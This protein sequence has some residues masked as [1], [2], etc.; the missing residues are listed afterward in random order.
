MVFINTSIKS[1]KY[2]T[3]KKNI[4]RNNVMRSLQKSEVLQKSQTL[5]IKNH[6]NQ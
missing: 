2:N 5:T 3:K 1:R 4:I 6:K